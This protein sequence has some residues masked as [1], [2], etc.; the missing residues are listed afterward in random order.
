M[1][2]LGSKES[3]VP[4]IIKLLKEKELLNTK[5]ISFFVMVFVEWEVW[6]LA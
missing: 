2:Y 4:H 3:L 5:T 1:R 6:L